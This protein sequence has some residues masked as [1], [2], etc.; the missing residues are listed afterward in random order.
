MERWDAQFDYETDNAIADLDPDKG[1]FTMMENSPAY[2][3]GFE[4]IALYV[5]RG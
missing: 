3:K 2:E 1:D 5:T 4:P